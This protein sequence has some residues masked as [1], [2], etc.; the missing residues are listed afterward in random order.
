MK[1]QI[2]LKRHVFLFPLDFRLIAGGVLP[3]RNLSLQL[4]RR[5]QQNPT[6]FCSTEALLLLR[7]SIGQQS[8]IRPFDSADPIAGIKEMRPALRIP[9][10]DKASIPDSNSS[11]TVKKVATCY[12]GIVP[13]RKRIRPLF[14]FTCHKMVQ[15]ENFGFIANLKRF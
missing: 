10:S 11:G 15:V 1:S 14:F 5:P 2:R 13:N 3:L 6:V 7:C 8:P 4:R 9:A 12:L